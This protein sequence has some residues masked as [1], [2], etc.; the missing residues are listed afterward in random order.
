MPQAIAV[1]ITD[2]A[3]RKMVRACYPQWKGR[4]IKI[5]PATRYQ[6]MDYWSEGSRNY[7][8]AYHLESG[9][10]KH[11]S[12]MTHSPYNQAAHA[13]VQIP[14]GIALVEHAI[15]AG[16]DMGIRIYVNP[17]NLAKLLPA[18]KQG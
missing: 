17:A 2:P 12:A 14:E 13:E 1:S 15:F 3:I 11:P 6:M 7:V 4:K 16:R 18:A 9:A 10:T 5:E 8:T